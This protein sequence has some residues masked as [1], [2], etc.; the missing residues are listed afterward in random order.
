MAVTDDAETKASTSPRLLMLTS[1][2]QLAG[3]R[4]E[5]IAEQSLSPDLALAASTLQV[6]RS[7]STLVLTEC[8]LPFG[9]PDAVVLAADDNEFQGR[10]DSGIPAAV[11]AAEVSMIVAAQR[12]PL[13]SNELME[14]SGLSGPVARRYLNG[15]EDKGAL[16]R[17]GDRF[18]AD[19][20]LRAVGRVFALEA[21]VSDW[22]S[23]YEQCL[24][25]GLF[26]DGTGLIM[27]RVTDKGRAPLLAMTRPQGVGVFAAGRWLSRPRMARHNKVRRLHASECVVAAL[28]LV[29]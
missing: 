8:P 25:Y 1:E 5:P 4:F 6:A 18:K 24:R 19:R 9:V 2:L 28:G 3:R 22:R 12:R 17:V 11:N 10:L 29:R 15:L 21:K 26:A 20:R 7:R 13:T 27:P 23:G 14:A 16:E